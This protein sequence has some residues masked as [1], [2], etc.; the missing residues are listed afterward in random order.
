M[1]AAVSTKNKMS[2]QTIAK[3]SILGALAFLVMLFEI[4]LPFIPSFY[5]LGVDEVVVLIG[6]FA[7]GPWAAVCIEALKIALNL[8]IGGSDT[9]G[10]GEIAN[11]LFG[12]AL[13]LPASI[14]YQKKKTR[15]NAIIGLF[16]GSICMILLGA[17]INYFVLLPAY[18]FFMKLPLDEVISAGH[19]INSNINSVFSMVLLATIPFN[20]IKCAVISAIV[21]LVY[22]RI[23]PLIKKWVVSLP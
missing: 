16:V 17:I 13:V 15:K 12:I 18:A 22:K 11:F 6:G 8:I 2:V 10:I 3:I 23:S 9:A 7:L 14:I 21:L 20:I 4:R 19:A 5:K 1:S